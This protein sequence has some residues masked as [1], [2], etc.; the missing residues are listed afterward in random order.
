MALLWVMSAGMRRTPIPLAVKDT[1]EEN[2]QQNHSILFARAVLR[3]AWG[4]RI[5]CSAREAFQ[6]ALH[7]VSVIER[8]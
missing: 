1:K 5:I 8:M 6:P 3:V 2:R 4:F 7:F